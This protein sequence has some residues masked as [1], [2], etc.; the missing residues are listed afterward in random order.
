MKITEAVNSAFR[1]VYKLL[2]DVQVRRPGREDREVEQGV[3]SHIV[4]SFQG[5]IASQCPSDIGGK[6]SDSR[7]R[8]F[9]L[10]QPYIP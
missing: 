10:L 2:D 9:G 3:I 7:R 6:H 1:L 5:E 4:V 8:L